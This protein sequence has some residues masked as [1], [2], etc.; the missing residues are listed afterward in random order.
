MAKLIITAE[1]MMRLLDK[2]PVKFP[3]TIHLKGMSKEKQKEL[4]DKI[5]KSG[6]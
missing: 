3:I 5:K 1:Q 6:K 2:A 4:F